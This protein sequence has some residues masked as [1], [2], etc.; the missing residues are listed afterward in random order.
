MPIL[1]LGP[2]SF[3]LSC[4]TI[5]P[6]WHCR[7]ACFLLGAGPAVWTARRR[8][9]KLRDRVDDKFGPLCRR[10]ENVKRQA[11]PIWRALGE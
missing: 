11:D 4:I 2:I 6:Y 3:A 10:A 1:D 8:A 9:G 7:I 5:R